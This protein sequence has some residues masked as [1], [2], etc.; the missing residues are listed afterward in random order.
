[1]AAFERAA[2]DEGVPL[3][4]VR[5]R[6]GQNAYEARLVLVRPDRYIAWT[7][8]H[9]PDDAGAVIGRAVGRA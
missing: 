1:M 7:G 8:D 5:D 3:T 4:I 6:I 2:R 9:A